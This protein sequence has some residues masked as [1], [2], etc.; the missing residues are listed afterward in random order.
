MRT[1]KVLMHPAGRGAATCVACVGNALL[2]RETIRSHKA[3]TPSNGCT[4]I[5][6]LHPLARILGHTHEPFTHTF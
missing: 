2:N 5:Y 1:S 6:I 3:A 4:E